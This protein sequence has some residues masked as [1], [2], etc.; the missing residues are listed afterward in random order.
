MPEQRY[1]YDA[2]CFTFRQ[3]KGVRRWYCVR[4]GDFRDDHIILIVEDRSDRGRVP[5]R[6][7]AVCPDGAVYGPTSVGV[8]SVLAELR[9]IGL[10]AREEKVRA[11]EKEVAARSKAFQ[12][13][14]R[15]EA[16]GRAGRIRD[17]LN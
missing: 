16:R 7:I 14:D 3:R 13:I 6:V 4:C 1:T 8:T 17:R 5:D 15:L 2:P 12:L 9:I 10:K 11:R